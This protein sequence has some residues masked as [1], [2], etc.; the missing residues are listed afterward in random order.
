MEL[1]EEAVGVDGGVDGEA[2]VFLPVARDADSSAALRNEKVLEEWVPVE[3]FVDEI[4]CGLLPDGSEPLRTVGRHPDEVALSLIH[5]SEP[6]RLGMISYA[7][8]CLKKKK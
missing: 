6:T 4:F 7:V 5:I 8:F 3:V 1:A 2:H